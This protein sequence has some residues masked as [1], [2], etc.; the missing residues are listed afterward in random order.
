MSVVKE[1]D[2]DEDEKDSSKSSKDNNLSI[3]SIGS[4]TSQKIPVPTKDLIFVRKAQSIALKSKDIMPNTT[5]NQLKKAKTVLIGVA[6]TPNGDLSE[7]NPEFQEQE[8]PLRLSTDHL[9]RI[10]EEINREVD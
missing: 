5:I 8:E 6:N 1:E 7:I 9:N 10:E 4:S 2:E 3:S